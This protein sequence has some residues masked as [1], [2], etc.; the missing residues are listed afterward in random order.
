[1]NAKLALG[2][3][4]VAL[5][6]LSVSAKDY[7]VD[8]VDG[9]DAWDGTAKYEDRDET[10]TPVKGPKKTFHGPTGV[11]TLALQ[12]YDVVHAAAGSYA[13]YGSAYNS[14]TNRLMITT[15]NLGVVADEGRVVTFIE[16]ASATEAGAVN[17]C[18]TDAVRCVYIGGTDSYVRGFTLRNGRTLNKD[19]GTDKDYNCGGCIYGGIAIDCTITGGG[20]SRR[21]RGP[22]G[23]TAVGCLITANNGGG[24]YSSY[25]GTYFSCVFDEGSAY[26]YSL[27][28][29]NT[30]FLGSN[31]PRGGVHFNGYMEGTRGSTPVLTNC[32]LKADSFSNVSADG[33]CQLTT[34]NELDANLVP[35]KTSKLMNR[36]HNEYYSEAFERLLGSTLKSEFGARD[37]QL[38][39]PR[40]S[41]TSIDIGAV[42]Y[43]WRGDYQ[44]AL[45]DSAFLAVE[46]ESGSVA[47]VTDG[48]SDPVGVALSAGA[49]LGVS[50]K[51]PSAEYGS[52]TYAFAAAV[53]GAGTLMVYLDDAAEPTW[54]FVAADGVTT[55]EYTAVGHALRFEMTG[56]D[57]TCVLSSF[58]T[59]AGNMWFVDVRGSDA[60]DGS[61]KYEDRDETASP[62]KGPKKTLQG[63]MAI[64]GLKAGD[65]VHA[66]PGIYNEGGKATSSG[67]TN[68]VEVIA[69][70]GLV[71]DFGPDVTVI[72]GAISEDPS[73]KN[74]CGPG[75]VRCVHVGS[76]AYVRGFT[77]RKG[78]T[79]VG[80]TTADFNGGGVYAW[81]A[82][83]DCVI[84]NCW[85]DYRGGAVH[86]RG[87]RDGGTVIRCRI[88][89]SHGNDN[90]AV[91]GGT[92]VSTWVS[93]DQVYTAGILLNCAVWNYNIRGGSTLELFNTLCNKN[94]TG[95]GSCYR[96]LIGGTK[97]TASLV[98]NDGSK[99]NC[100]ETVMSNWFANGRPKA[101]SVPVDAGETDYYNTYFPK[102]WKRFRDGDAFGGQRIY[103]AKIDLGASE[104][105]WRGDF[106]KA[107]SRRG[108]AVTEAGVNVTTN[109][110]AGLDI[111]AGETLKLRIVSERAVGDCTVAVTGSPVVKLNGETLAGVGGVYT[112]RAAVGTF[113][114]LEIIAPQDAAATVESV[115]LPKAG[116]LLLLR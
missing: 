92:L 20:C 114:D 65:V 88:Y 62:V 70:V 36:G 18:G 2:S 78:R 58:T 21:G 80:T 105:D 46:S 17:G 22:R 43:D 44:A 4:L 45:S 109:A 111:S 57:S 31:G 99:T 81:G 56:E 85:A 1:M 101:G 61:A 82:V 74:G 16:G 93:A 66:A 90:Y 27:D 95:D 24:D 69:G 91:N 26:P 113:Y 112:F 3:V 39:N 28:S 50:W 54:T 38:K 79:A 13:E 49:A 47:V 51:C 55:N 110:H 42:E 83:V 72:E 34:G 77:L 11:M 107:L 100:G 12:P 103:N 60:W 97:S 25:K 14:L 19:T 53:T 40:Y 7:Y 63:S 94:V 5:S 33:D 64:V 87:D 6:A 73:A 96:S 9:N 108:V 102:A 59:T 52:E 86:C 115:A 48:E 75:A 71:A 68:R 84:S 89:D 104:Y 35:R 23:V 37:Y 41:G 32:V 8:A 30:I 106:A 76:G 29:Y 98:L 10:V 15:A 67:T 116:L